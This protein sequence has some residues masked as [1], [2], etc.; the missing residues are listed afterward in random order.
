M[1]G[2]EEL[3]Y[4]KSNREMEILRLRRA[5]EGLLT[6]L[7]TLWGDQVLEGELTIRVD[8]HAVHTALGLL[9]R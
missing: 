8:E 4:E 6:H 2:L 5:L 1:D 7:P 3:R 9:H